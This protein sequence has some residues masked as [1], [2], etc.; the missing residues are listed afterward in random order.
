MEPDRNS[1]AVIVECGGS[2]LEM[3]NI[4]DECSCKRH[5]GQQHGQKTNS[6]QQRRSIKQLHLQYFEHQSNTS[7]IFKVFYQFSAKMHS[8]RLLPFFALLSLAA[9]APQVAPIEYMPAPLA[10]RSNITF[11][12]GHCDRLLNGTDTAIGCLDGLCC[13]Q[14]GYCGTGPDYCS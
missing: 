6:N 10:A 13:S 4:G 9:A 8:F 12:D 5:Q 7:K 14:W 2:R 3:T 1:E 11:P